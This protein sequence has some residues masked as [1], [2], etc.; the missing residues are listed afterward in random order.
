MKMIIPDYIE[1]IKPNDAQDIVE[2]WPNGAWKALELGFGRDKVY[3]IIHGN[4]PTDN[5]HAV[6]KLLQMALEI[7]KN[8]NET[9]I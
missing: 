2:N 5:I 9:N 3:V 1:N 4:G 7:K 8:V 6:Q